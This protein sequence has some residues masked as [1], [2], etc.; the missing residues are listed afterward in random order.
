MLGIM[1]AER[2]DRALTRAGSR[3][4]AA[5]FVVRDY[6]SAQRWDVLY[7]ALSARWESLAPYERYEHYQC[8][9]TGLP[10]SCCECWQYDDELPAGFRERMTRSYHLRW[11]EA[12]QVW[13]R[14]QL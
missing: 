14:K 5:R 9:R 13:Y 2:A 1:T 12:E 3:F 10:T 4:Y 11:D 8:P 6:D 7:D